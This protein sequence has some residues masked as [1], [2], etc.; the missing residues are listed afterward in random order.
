M[1]SKLLLPVEIHTRVVVAVRA[2]IHS[3][4][5]GARAGML[6]DTSDTGHTDPVD[7]TYQRSIRLAEV[8]SRDETMI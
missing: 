8:S 7:S 3:Y 1:Y 6:G 2:P 4:L 5:V